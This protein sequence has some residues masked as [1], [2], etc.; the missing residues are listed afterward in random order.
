VRL[1]GLAQGL[2][3]L[4]PGTPERK[5]PAIWSG[6]LQSMGRHHVHLSP[7]EATATVVGRRRGWAVVLDVDACAMQR[8]G[9]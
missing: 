1:Y 6:G 4:S 9:W 5:L 7:D 8:D 2:H 3:P